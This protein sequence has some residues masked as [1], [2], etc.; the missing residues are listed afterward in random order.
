MHY[1]IC[2]TLAC[3]TLCAGNNGHST[4]KSQETDSDLPTFAYKTLVDEEN[5]IDTVLFAPNDSSII[6]SILIG[7][8]RSTETSIVGALFRLSNK[9]IIEELI[10]AHQRG[11]IIEIILDPEAMSA[12]QEISKMSHAKIPLYLYNQKKYGTYMHHKFLIF[13]NTLGCSYNNYSPIS[14][15]VVHGS[16]NLTQQGFNGNRENI[17]FRNKKTIVNA[18]TNEIA[19]LKTNT[20]RYLLQN[21]CE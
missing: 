12:S 19:N 7:L 2:I 6:E 14:A 21:C 13:Y 8:I 15:I 3:I 10:A 11:V 17:N 9:K 5:I 1:Y 20:D 16:L 18:F 4:H